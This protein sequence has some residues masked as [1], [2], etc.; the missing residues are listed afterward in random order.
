M[1]VSALS[2]TRGPLSRCQLMPSPIT[3]VPESTYS[4]SD[5]LNPDQSLHVGAAL[6][7]PNGRFTLVLQADGSLVLSWSGGAAR[8]ATGTHGRTVAR[9]TMQSDGNFALY[10]PVGALWAS[11]TAGHPGAFL[12]VQ[13]DGNVVIY[14]Q[15]GPLW[16]TGTVTRAGRR[17][18]GCTS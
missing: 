8:W 7:S 16:A 5:R 15:G 4:M 2:R 17:R 6:T 9:A 10:G 14:G 18:R 3:F 11:G 1:I 13:N 12:A